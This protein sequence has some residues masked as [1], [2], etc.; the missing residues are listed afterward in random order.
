MDVLY[1]IEY[2]TETGRN[3][4]YVFA[5]NEEAAEKEAFNDILSYVADPDSAEIIDICEVWQGSNDDYI[6]GDCGRYFSTPF[7]YRETHGFTDGSAETFCEC[8]HCRS[9]NIMDKKEYEN[10]VFDKNI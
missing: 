1:K 8:P 7:Y 10:Y 9:D 5:E 4:D 6:C 2:K 3:T